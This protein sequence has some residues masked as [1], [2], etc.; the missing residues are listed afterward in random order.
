V[1]LNTNNFIRLPIV[2]T[3]VYD[4]RNYWVSLLR[5]SSGIVNIR[6]RNVSETGSVAVL[7]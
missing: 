2:L 5:P 6:K 1:S 4:T 7:G 3:M